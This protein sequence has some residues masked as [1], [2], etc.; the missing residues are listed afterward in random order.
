MSKTT[1]KIAKQFVEGNWMML[2]LNCSSYAT[3]VILDAKNVEV[4]G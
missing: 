4:S 3:V 2:I 1:L